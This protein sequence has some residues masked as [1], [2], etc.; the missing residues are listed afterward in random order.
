MDGTVINSQTVKETVV[1]TVQ[2]QEVTDIH[3]HLFSPAF[4]GLLLW[5][6]DD[7]ITYHY[8]IAETFRKAQISYERY[9]ALSKIEQ[10][11][12][13][14]QTLF[15][16]N[17]PISEACRGIILRMARNCAFSQV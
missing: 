11:D 3:T 16:E 1:K 4:G 14:W 13:I 15:I 10:A 17:S 9:W 2:S 8:L 6:I 5:G 7:L 12:L